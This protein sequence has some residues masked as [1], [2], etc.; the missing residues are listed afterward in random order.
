[1]NQEDRYHTTSW[2]GRQVQ[3]QGADSGQRRPQSSPG[4]ERRSRRRKE[5]GE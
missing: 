1:M 4:E 2:D 5:A 3:R